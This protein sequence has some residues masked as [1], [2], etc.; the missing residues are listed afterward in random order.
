MEKLK[1]C[2]NGRELLKQYGLG[3]LDLKHAECYLFEQREFLSHAG[4]PLKSIYFIISGKA[5]VFI[6]LSGGKQLLL[7]HFTT[8]GMIGDI[9]L[10]TNKPVNYTTIQ[11]VSDLKCITI[12]L[13]IYSSEL[14]ANNR[15]INIVAKELAEKL[16]QRVINSAITTLHPLETRL[17]AYIAQS[18]VNGIFRET[19]T[20]VAVMLGTS[21]RHLLRCLKNLSAA[22]ILCKEHSGYR[23]I[24]QKSLV[25]SAG[26]LYVLK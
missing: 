23:I 7:A 12:P 13:D 1:I 3:T 14:K 10:V 4:E 26:D 21:Y 25:S 15:F 8:K 17:C 16:T 19:L 24:D 11:A 5:K 9:E 22:G 6:T 2:D 20:D 18:S